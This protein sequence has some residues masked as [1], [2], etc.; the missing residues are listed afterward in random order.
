MRSETWL[1]DVHIAVDLV[2]ALFAGVREEQDG[3][4]FG[5]VPVVDQA[6]AQFVAVLESGLRTKNG[7]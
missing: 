5:V 2:D 7:P 3:Q 1:R 4:V 6:D